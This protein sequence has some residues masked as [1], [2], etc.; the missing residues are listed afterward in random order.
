MTRYIV[1]VGHTR[2]E[3]EASSEM[4]AIR[5]FLYAN[6]FESLLTDAPESH[7]KNWKRLELSI[8]FN[9]CEDCCEPSP[10]AEVCEQCLAERVEDADHGCLE[11][12][13]HKHG[14]SIEEVD[15]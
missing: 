11:P 5:T 10:E 13:K 9:V 12:W 2:M 4:R 1:E 3:L 8:G 6:E 14:L 15:G 7:Y